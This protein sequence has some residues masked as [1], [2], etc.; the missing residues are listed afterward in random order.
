MGIT[1]EENSESQRYTPQTI[2][3]LSA[4]LSRL[5]SSNLQEKM[6]EQQQQV[7]VAPPLVCRSKAVLG[8][9]FV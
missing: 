5:I 2:L 3:F 6:E 4:F 7:E 8:K 9:V 1:E